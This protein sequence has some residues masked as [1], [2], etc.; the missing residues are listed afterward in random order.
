MYCGMVTIQIGGLTNGETVILERYLDSNWS[1]ALETP[2][3]LRTLRLRI[4]DGQV[5][6]IGGAT[7]LNVPGDLNPIG[8]A[9]TARLNCYSPVLDPLLGPAQW[10]VLSSPSGRFLPVVLPDSVSA[11]PFSQRLDGYVRCSGTNV[12][13]AVVVA[14]NPLADMSFTAACLAT[15]TGYFAL[16]LPP[17]T[18]VL[19]AA[20]PGFVTDMA[21]MPTVTLPPGVIL[22]NTLDLLPATRTLSGKLVDAAD[23]N[24]TLPAIFMMANSLTDRFAPAWTDTNGNFTVAVT[25]DAWQLEPAGQD[26]ARHGFLFGDS[27][28]QRVFLTTTGNVSGIVLKARRANALIYGR[29]SN[30]TN[31]PLAGLR[32]Q[33]SGGVQG[34]EFDPDYA[35]DDNGDFAVAII[36]GSDNWWNFMADPVL[37]PGMSNQVLSGFLF[38]VSLLSGEAR[39]QDVRA[40]FA[41][42][43]IAGTVRDVSGAPVPAVGVIGWASLG[44]TTYYGSGF[45][46]D[47]NGNY[48]MNVAG[49]PWMLQLYCGDLLR[50]GYN[51]APAKTVV[52][53]P[54]NPVANFTVFPLGRPGLSDARRLSPSDFAFE[55]HGEPF[56]WYEIQYSTDL[57]NWNFLTTIQPQWDGP[58]YVNTTVTDPSAQTGRRF[59][60]AVLSP[61]LPMRTL[62]R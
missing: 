22:T 23:T 5:A 6:T 26:I 2:Y 55:L 36:G 1:G 39:R 54:T 9:I 48:A 8:G 4:T 43:R 3:D 18:Y 35:A 60:R 17:G 31:G 11:E 10:W 16:P 15:W 37:N 30:Q 20:K 61:M 46:T 14:L 12:P 7:N 25:A 34:E 24:A 38:N 57:T 40:L 28:A 44:G 51:C 19:V 53:P 50:A 42:N 41:T 29:A 32:F 33:I 45:M 62:G 56:T 52:L 13:G 49:S 47:F 27:E 58:V 21:A 59:Y